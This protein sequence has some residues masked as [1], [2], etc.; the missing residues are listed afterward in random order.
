MNAYE[1]LSACVQ[2]KPYAVKPS[3]DSPMELILICEENGA[4]LGITHA[5]RRLIEQCNGTRTVGEIIARMNRETRTPLETLRRLLWDLDRYGFLVKNP[6]GTK[7][8]MQ[9]EGYWGE[10]SEFC[11]EMSYVPLLGTWETRLGQWLLSPFVCIAALVWFPFLLF[12]TQALL[13]QIDPFQINGS[14]A[15]A[16]LAIF[17][18]LLSGSVLS[19][20]AMAMTLQAVHPVKPDVLIDYRHGLPLFRLDARRLRALP[21]RKA[22]CASIVPTF[23]FVILSSVLLFLAA[24]LPAQGQEWILHISIGLW[25]L[26]LWPA[27]P[28][29]STALS[30]EVALRLRGESV[31]WSLAASVKHVFHILLGRDFHHPAQERLYR[32]WGGWSVA[33]ILLAIQVLIYIPRMNFYDV[34]NRLVAEKNPVVLTLLF[35]LLAVG[36]AALAASILTF[37]AWLSREI[38]QEIRRRFWPQK[39]YIL[40]GLALFFA[41]FTLAQMFWVAHPQG[42]AGSPAGKILIG[43]V[44]FIAGLI[45]WMREGRGYE[46]LIYLPMLLCGGSLSIH[47][48]YHLFFYKPP[49]MEEIYAM[50]AGGSPQTVSLWV[51]LSLAGML[52][53]SVLYCVYLLFLYVFFFRPIWT[54][55]RPVIRRVLL[56]LPLL[57][58]ILWGMQH[59]PL[60]DSMAGKVGFYLLVVQLLLIGILHV[61]LGSARNHSTSLLGLG[62]AMLLIGLLWN[63][64]PN[65]FYPSEQIYVLGLSLLTGALLL[66]ASAVSKIALGYTPL[67][68]KSIQG[69][70]KKNGNLCGA[71]QYTVQGLYRAAPRLFCPPEISPESMRRYLAALHRITGTRA[72][73]ALARGVALHLPWDRTQFYANSLPIA[74]SFPP[75]IGWTPEKVEQKLR[76][77]PTFAAVDKEEIKKLAVLVRF[78]IYRSG[79]TIIHQGENEGEIYYIVEGQVSVE[80]CHPVGH[81]LLTFLGPDDFMG[82]IGFLTGSER[83]ASIRALQ[84]VLVLRISRQDITEDLPQTYA[85][86]RAAVEGESWHPLLLHAHIFSEFSPA[87]NARLYLESKRIVLEPGQSLWLENPEYESK[88]AVLL[89]GKGTIILEEIE[90]NLLAGQ[91]IGFEEALQNQPMKGRIR[92]EQS[93]RILLMDRKALFEALAERLIPKEIMQTLEYASQS[94]PLRERTVWNF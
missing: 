75:L 43:S 89:S 66:R 88:I 35:L 49:G 63:Q 55:S 33:C 58:L 37:G 31:L 39:D 65:R 22:I 81:S 8:K 60:V 47:G 40:I 16:L 15:P 54:G 25:L 23:L 85:A 70:G 5:E 80:L 93:S 51:Q 21:L 13:A 36:G 52:L 84:P 92:A 87:L 14:L 74:V 46:P 91:L 83:T 82:E 57:A 4:A 78:A 62:M 69:N 41:L 42:L 28:W 45:L 2:I 50:E 76:N 86:L 1:I 3:E 72:L 59:L 73:Q 56:I 94:R 29:A 11:L 34:L 71:F 64:P 30:R 12:Y 32:Y 53:S 26:A 19:H 9:A 90:T 7:S 18:S 6:W 24:F 48:F 10:C 44:I 38:V 79:E 17:L 27:L 67:S 61:S 20:W 68:L 77:I